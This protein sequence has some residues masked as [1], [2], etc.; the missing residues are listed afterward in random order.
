MALHSTVFILKH[1]AA[2]MVIAYNLLL[3]S[4]AGYTLRIN[5]LTKGAAGTDRC[6][7]AWSLHIIVLLERL[8][9]IR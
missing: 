5:Q 4:Q 7:G 9:A 8:D 1:Y 3:G 6:A 2:A